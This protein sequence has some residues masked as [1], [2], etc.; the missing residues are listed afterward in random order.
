MPRRITMLD[1][2]ITADSCTPSLAARGK[3]NPGQSPR[4]A[5]EPQP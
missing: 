4:A 2:R 5:L 3:A 1:G